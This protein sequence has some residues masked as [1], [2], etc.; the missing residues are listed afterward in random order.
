MGI[1]FVVE[2]AEFA[3]VFDND[4][5]IKFNNLNSEV[6]KRKI[7]MLISKTHSSCSRMS[8]DTS[9]RYS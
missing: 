2:Y 6:N 7:L 4:L 8:Q 5:F 9:N 1:L 3:R